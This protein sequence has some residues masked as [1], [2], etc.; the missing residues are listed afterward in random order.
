M[1]IGTRLGLAKA[2]NHQRSK[3]TGFFLLIS[4]VSLLSHS[5]KNERTHAHTLTHSYHYRNRTTHDGQ[6]SIISSKKT[7]AHAPR[8]TCVLHASMCVNGIFWD[9]C[10][11]L[12]PLLTPTA[13]EPEQSNPTALSLTHQKVLSFR[14]KS[15][16]LLYHAFFLISSLLS[17]LLLAPPPAHPSDLSFKFGSGSTRRP[18]LSL[19]RHRLLKQRATLFY[20]VSPP[21]MDL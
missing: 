19:R 11:S 4:F 15:C 8:K 13:S 17:C 12:T 20:Y 18:P 16:A 5:H 7:R 14:P 10:T 21:S 2:G 6:F 9:A 3:K 1:R